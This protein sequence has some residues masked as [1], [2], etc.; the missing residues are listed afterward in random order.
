MDDSNSNS[1]VVS[2][3][4]KRGCKAAVP[5]EL[6][7]ES[8]CVL[9]FIMGIENA[10]GEMRR[11]AAME[12]ATMARRREIDGYVKATALKLSDVATSNTR[13]S[14][15]LKRK[16][17]S[18]FLTLMNLQESLDRSRSRALQP[19]PPQRVVDPV[20]LVAAAR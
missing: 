12:L 18:T 1:A 17:L 13:L 15:E 4:C 5:H 14:D 2:I 19:R 3:S 10:C 20:R 9:H 8:I 6:E 7:D 16:V 11:E